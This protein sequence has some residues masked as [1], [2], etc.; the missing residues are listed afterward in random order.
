MTS[1][2]YSITLLHIISYGGLLTDACLI[3]SNLI[4]ETP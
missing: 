1:T 2:Y 3:K 4:N